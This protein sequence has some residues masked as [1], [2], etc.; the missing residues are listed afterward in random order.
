MTVR[1][2]N[3]GELQQAARELGLNLSDADAVSFHGLMQGQLDAYDLVDDM[4]A[5]LPEV[6]YPRTPGVRPQPEDNPYGAWAVKSR[7][8]GAPRGKLT[9]KRVAIKDNVC[10]AGVPMMNGASILEGYVPE[11]D[12]TIVSRMLDEGADILGKSVCEYYCASGG[13]H[14][15]ANGVVENPVVPGHNAGGSSSGST[16][17]VMAN[18]VD[19]ATG[20][21]QG[22]SIRIPAS[23]CGA[24][25]LKPT[26][27]LVPYTGIFAVELTV[28]HAGPITRTVA[29]NA[30]MLE[31]MAGPDGLDPRQSGAPAQPYTQ[32]LAKGVAG[33]RIGV[34]PEGFGLLGAEAEVDKRVREAA[35]RLAHT[36]AHVCD[37]SVPLHAAGAAIWTPIF[38]EGATDL[39]MRGNAYGT[40]MKGVFLES[41]LDAHAG[42]RDR[43]DELSETLKLGI[44]TG[45]YMSSRN[46]GR[47]YGKAQNLNRLL[48]ADYNRA[49]GEVDLLLMP[50]TPMATTPLPGPNA[51]REEIIGRAFEMV[52]NT[53]PTCVTGH[54]AISVPV[55][56][57]SD[58]RPIG[59]MLIARHLDEMTLYRAAAAL[60][61]CYR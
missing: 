37:I 7:I 59:A 44:L 17:L 23:Y 14:T 4:V 60:E 22:G 43:A 38:L 1:R 10:V 5:P 8:Q 53:A 16:A 19:M 58:G 52:A 12:A 11:I 25:G 2:P 47:Y 30:L 18:L 21:D 27:G 51:S 34:V 45:H 32:A 33:L 35:E 26:H 6:K 48:T 13:S 9:G 40:N 46:R 28:D 55:G 29:D 20:G 15:S 56:K 3:V 54:P 31:V 50:T 36:G 61:A 24:V 49:L 39:M 41:L 42:W 57:T